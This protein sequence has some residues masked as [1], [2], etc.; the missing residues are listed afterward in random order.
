MQLIRFYAM[1]TYIALYTTDKARKSLPLECVCVW[2]ALEHE[3]KCVLTDISGVK[4]KKLIQYAI[5]RMCGFK[6]V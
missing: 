3:N 2:G 4:R 1:S 5:F 6:E